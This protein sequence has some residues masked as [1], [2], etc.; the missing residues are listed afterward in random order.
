MQR[1]IGELGSEGANTLVVLIGGLH[2]NEPAGISA[3]NQLMD[4]LSK[5]KI[6]VKGKV[7]ALA[8]NLEAL[9]R[10]QRQV[11]LDLNRIWNEDYIQKARDR[12]D[13]QVYRE[14]L[15]ILRILDRLEADR[16]AHKIFMDLHTTSGSGGA[17][18]IVCNY[19]QAKH[20]VDDLE[21]PIIVGLEEKLKNTAIEYMAKKG[22]ITYAF[23][24]GKH[25]DTLSIENLYWAAYMTLIRSACI[26]VV[27]IPDQILPIQQRLRI[28]NKDIPKYFHFDYLYRIAPYEKFVMRPGFRNFSQIKE[29]DVLAKN[30][31]GIIK[32]PRDGYLLMPLY[33]AEG[34]DGFYVIQEVKS[35]PSRSNS[36]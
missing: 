31:N 36:D 20:I 13:Q 2:G 29:G 18:N 4:T 26:E 6:G 22:F 24:G 28:K 25:D 5:R 11:G 33:Q 10:K 35:L 23:E 8:G 27:D 21:V 16:Y 14:L 7:I 9:R 3:L 12:E 32:A 1:I 30:Q 17:F 19:D 34:N 15:D